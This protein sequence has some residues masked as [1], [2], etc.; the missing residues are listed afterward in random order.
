MNSAASPAIYGENAGFDPRARGRVAAFHKT[1][2]SDTTT[3]PRCW[4]ATTAR[5]TSCF[6]VGF[7]SR[8]FRLRKSASIASTPSCY[9]ASIDRGGGRR[10]RRG[11]R[12]QP[13]FMWVDRA[14]DSFA[15]PIAGWVIHE[16]KK[17]G[18]ENSRGAVAG[19]GCC[20]CPCRRVGLH[21][22]PPSS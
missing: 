16:G 13:L 9:R 12:L 14:Y 11:L 20:L 8:I 17:N 2:R 1:R 7:R 15:A 10:F 4:L 5:K 3:R 21:W 22:P 19:I 18:E 6:P